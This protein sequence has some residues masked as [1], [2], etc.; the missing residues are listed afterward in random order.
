MQRLRRLSLV[1]SLGQR[2][3]DQAVPVLL[4]G[5]V[6]ALQQV[7]VEGA[8]SDAEHDADQP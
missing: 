3:H 1:P 7:E 5:G 4:G 8:N 6:Q 2:R